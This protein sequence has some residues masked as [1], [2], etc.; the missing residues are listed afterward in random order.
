M[1]RTILAIDPGTTE[2]GFA[3][4]KGAEIVYAGKIPNQEMKQ[5]VVHSASGQAGGHYEIDELV[6]ERIVSYGMSV[7]QEVHDTCVWIGRFQE[8]WRSPDRVHLIERK[9]VKMHVC[10]NGKAK[11]KNIRQAMIDMFGA[12]GTKKN[13]GPTFGITGDAWQ[14]LALAVTL[15][16]SLKA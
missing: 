16:D 11:D 3:I 9:D 12:P 8:R 6:I 7:G 1:I 5:L 14:A 15:R 13:P 10:H 4:L 2:S